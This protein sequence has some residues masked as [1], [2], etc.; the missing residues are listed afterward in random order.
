[1]NHLKV[2]K[3]RATKRSHIGVA[4]IPA[5][6]FKAGM[7]FAFGIQIVF[8]TLDRKFELFL[9]LHVIGRWLAEK[10]KSTVIDRFRWEKKNSS[11]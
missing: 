9:K 4:A 5:S 10:T 8:E 6:Y 7:V 1:M 11:P 3:R 2:P